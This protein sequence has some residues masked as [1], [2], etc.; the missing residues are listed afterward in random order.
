VIQPLENSPSPEVQKQ[1]APAAAGKPSDTSFVATLHAAAK[2]G[3]SSK[4]ESTN[5]TRERVA[6]PEGE[7]WAST[8]PG[9]HYARIITGPRAGQYINLTHGER[10]GETFTI[11]HREGKKLHVYKES[12]TEVTIKPSVDASDVTD[13]AKRAKNPPADRPPKGERWAPVEGHNNYAD[14]LEGPRNGL[15][16][17]ISGGIRDGMAFQIVKKGDK[18]FHVYGT[19]KDKQMIQVAPKDDDDKKP[20][21]TAATG[22]GG[23][24]AATGTGGTPA[25]GATTGGTTAGGGS[26]SSD[27][28]ADAVESSGTGGTAAP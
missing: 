21:R 26:T 27:D 20:S 6:V 17:N 2:P 28:L 3:A 24:A 19:G 7:T 23:T 8:K 22:A 9:A 1:S 4:P 14:I 13:A 25:P 15:Y 12:G 5:P 18:V 16:V 11:E 10:R